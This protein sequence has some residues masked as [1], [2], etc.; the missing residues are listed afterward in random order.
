MGLHAR[1]RQR[2]RFGLRNK[3]KSLVSFASLQARIYAFDWGALGDRDA[4]SCH[5][6]KRKWDKFPQLKPINL[7]RDQFVHRF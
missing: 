3:L 1:L 7:V 6:G 5:L 2:K 4:S